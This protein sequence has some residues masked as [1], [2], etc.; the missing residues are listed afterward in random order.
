MSR[1]RNIFAN[2][3]LKER[4]RLNFRFLY[5][6][7][8][9]NLIQLS[10]KRKFTGS[11]WPRLILAAAALMQAT[12]EIRAQISIPAAAPT[13]PA[14]GDATSAGFY[15][16]PGPWGV[17]KCYPIF[18][19]APRAMVDAYPLPSSRPRWSLPDSEFANLA[20]IFSMAGLPDSLGTNLLQPAGHVREGG[21]VHLFP[22]IADVENLDSEV[23]S[24]W[25]TELSKYEINEFHRDPVL[26]LTDKV[27]DWYRTSRVRPA[28]VQKITQLAYRRGETWA[29][30]DLGLL[31]NYAESDTEA[32]QI[33]KAFTRTRSLL[34]KVEVSSTTNVDDLMS[35]WTLGYGMRRKDIEPILLSLQESGVDE[36]L[37]IAHILPALPRKLI[38]TYPSFDLA[39]HGMLPDCHWTSLNFLNFDPHEYLLDARLATSS[40]LEGFTPI[41]PPYKYGDILFFVDN[42]TGDAF[43]SCVYLAD[44]LVFTKNGRNQL[45]P[46]IITTITDVNRM[47]LYRGDGRVQAYRRKLQD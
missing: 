9:P 39:R 4:L 27:E 38:Y 13:A 15:A 28:L 20:A 24:K 2:P 31:L 26:I 5:P 36:R 35:Y 3:L 14:S 44:E 19:E 32:R 43:H 16:K 21:W 11:H 45:S 42:T 30:S 6:Q 23:R 37:D 22:S 41:P 33:F 47:Y 7:M 12:P 25:Y 17:I 18:L 29:F 46:W 40:V 1:P 8:H 10:Q 34:V